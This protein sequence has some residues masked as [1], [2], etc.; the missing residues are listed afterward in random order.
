MDEGVEDILV[1]DINRSLV[2][3]VRTS[4]KVKEDRREP[5]YDKLKIN[6]A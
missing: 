5:L 1:T 6:N 2:S 3:R 4:L